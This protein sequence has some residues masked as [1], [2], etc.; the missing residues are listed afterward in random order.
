M[1]SAAASPVRPSRPSGAILLV[2]AT[3]LLAGCTLLA[4]QPSTFDLTLPG[5]MNLRP[6][7][8]RLFDH[9]GT[10]TRLELAVDGPLRPPAVG[11]DTFAIG[12][13]G[14]PNAVF[15]AWLGGMCDEQVQIEYTGSDAT[16]TVTTTR[17][18]GGCR[19]AGI[20]RSVIV[21]FA[22]PVDVSRFVVQAM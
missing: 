19:L 9:A 13:P 18:Q 5:V 14:R 1:E 16:F 21:V 2:L 22:T 12:V 11:D 6:L 7:P 20:S 4:R 17:Q 3:I 10:I 15:V 8:V